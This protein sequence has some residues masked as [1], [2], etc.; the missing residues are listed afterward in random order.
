MRFHV[1]ALSH[2][3]TLKEYSACAFTQKVLNL[4]KLLH[5]AGHTVYHYGVKGGDPVCSENIAVVDTATFA[6]V[7][8]AYDWRVDGWLINRE[9]DA[10]RMFAVNAVTEVRKRAKP[11]DFLLC[12]FGLDHKPI[13]DALPQ[14]I[15]VETGIGYPHPWARWRVYESYAWLHYHIGK[16]DRDGS[17]DWYHVVIPN[18]YD[19]A[20]FPFTSNKGDYHIFLGRPIAKK[21][22]EIA[23]DACVAAGIPLYVAGQ[24][25][26]QVPPGVTHL[27]VLDAAS[28]ARWVGNAQALWAPTWYLEPFGGVA[29]EAQLLGTPV[30]STDFGA[31]AETIV[32]GATGFRCRTFE[33]FVWAAK[34]VHRL[35]PYTCRE[36]AEQRYSLARVGAMYEEYFDMLTR[37]H[38]DPRGWYASNDRRAQL[39][40]LGALEGPRVSEPM[41]LDESGNP[42]PLPGRRRHEF[43]LHG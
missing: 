8:E 34:H 14:L 28:R 39:D 9:N 24:G 40:W 27:G 12:T 43:A 42:D 26:Q 31:F 23:I 1:L 32:H 35:D 4:C 5:E 25:D 3:R 7:H 21:G 15:A 38:R 20:E 11:G 6:R 33:Q 19:L 29:A 36:W 41:F 18:G 2:T 13:A 30:I 22:R 10:Y 16:E 17:P 37:Q